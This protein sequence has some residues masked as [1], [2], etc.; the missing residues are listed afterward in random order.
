MM[1]WVCGGLDT[2]Q[3]TVI[4][5]SPYCDLAPTTPHKLS[6]HQSLR[7]TCHIQDGNER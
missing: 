4:A 2:I 7:E 1:N 5:D 3:D 6:M